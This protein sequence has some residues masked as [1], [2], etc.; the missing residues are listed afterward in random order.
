MALFSA[1]YG[2]FIPLA[3]KRFIQLVSDNNNW[4]LIW[5]GVGV[6]AGLY[7]LQTFIRVWFYRSLDQFGGKYMSHL[8]QKMELKLQQGNMLDISKK[9]ESAVRNILFTDVIHIFTAVGHHIPSIISSGLLIVSL[10]A[11]LLMNDPSTALLISIASALGIVISIFS[12][13][14]IT[15]ASK[16]VNMRLKEYDSCCTEYIKIQYG[17]LS[18]F[19]QGLP[20]FCVAS[21]RR[22]GFPLDER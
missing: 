5:Q 1:A 10:L 3:S 21:F 9:D 17:V 12:K 2:I 19:R 6:F 15:N 13:K 14:Y 22:Y 7:L 4:M 20:T 8:S 11:F 18:A 16:A